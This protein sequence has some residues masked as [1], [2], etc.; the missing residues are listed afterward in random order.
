MFDAVTSSAASARLSATRGR[1][2]SRPDHWNRLVE[3]A[4][5]ARLIVAGQPADD[6]INLVALTVFAFCF[7]QVK[8]IN[9]C[10]GK[11]G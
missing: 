5:E 8:G 11:F 4:F 2:R 3:G 6:G 1:L 7:L 9:F 10:E